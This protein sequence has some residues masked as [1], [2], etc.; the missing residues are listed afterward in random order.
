V[1]CY[2]ARMSWHSRRIGPSRLAAGLDSDGLVFFDLFGFDKRNPVVLR[3]KDCKKE[4]A[5]A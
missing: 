3:M 2:G 4:L 5:Y 1:V